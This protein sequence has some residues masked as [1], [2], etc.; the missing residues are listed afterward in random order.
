MLSFHQAQEMAIFSVKS[1]EILNYFV[2][3]SHDKGLYITLE[4]EQGWNPEPWWQEFDD[5]GVDICL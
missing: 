2:G 4:T 1:G 5:K 3:R